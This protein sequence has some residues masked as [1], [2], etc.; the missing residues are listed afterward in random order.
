MLLEVRDDSKINR[1]NFSKEVQ[2]TYLKR[3]LMQKLWSVKQLVGLKSWRKLF[4]KCNQRLKS[5]QNGDQKAGSFCN[6]LMWLLHIKFCLYPI[7]YIRGHEESLSSGRRR[8]LRRENRYVCDVVI[9]KG[10]DQ[11]FTVLK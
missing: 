2:S 10:N 4:G 8:K 1:M 5:S 7:L 11:F 6:I 9:Y 3:N